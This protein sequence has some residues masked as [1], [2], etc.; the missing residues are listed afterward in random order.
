MVSSEWFS[1]G[2]PDSPPLSPRIRGLSRRSPS[3]MSPWW[4]ARCRQTQQRSEQSIS[5]IL[6]SQVR[7]L[8]TSGAWVFLALAAVPASPLTIAATVFEA[9]SDPVMW[10]LI[11]FMAVFSFISVG[12]AATA[13]CLAVYSPADEP[14]RFDRKSGKLYRYRIRQWR[15]VGVNAPVP[16][17]VS[18]Y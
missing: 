8:K 2:G 1:E 18:R 10:G 17:A 5:A 6:R 14:I 12:W 11:A 7:S 13:Y 15:F 16:W 4:T 9:L 3:A